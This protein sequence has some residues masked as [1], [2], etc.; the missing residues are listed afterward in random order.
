M[1]IYREHSVTQDL[2][3]LIYKEAQKI[4]DPRPSNGPAAD[5]TLTDIIMYALAVFHLKHPS[6]LSSDDSRLQPTIQSN[7]KSLYHVERIPCDSYLRDVIDLIPTQNFRAFFTACFAHCQRRSWLKRYQYFK[8]GYLAPIDATQTFTSKKIH[9]QNCCIKNAD[10]PKKPTIY[11]HQL[12]AICIVRPG[13]KTVLPL[14][15]EPITQQVDASKNDCEVRALER[16]L[17][18]L[19]REHYHLKLILNFDDLYSKGPTLKLVLSHGHHFIAVAKNSDHVALVEAVKALELLGKVRYFSFSDKQGHQH[20][21]RYVNGVPLNQSHPD[22]LVNY[23]DYTE[24]DKEGKQLYHNSWVTSLTLLNYMY[25]MKVLRGGR[26][27][28]KIENETFNTLKH[29]GY[30]LE[31]NYGHG[32]EHLSS[33]FTCLMFTAF[34]MDQYFGQFS[35]R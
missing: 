20:W 4:P 11:Y 19:A 33:N 31:H 1:P 6:L 27:K 10:N 9:C 15:P 23:L 34:L 7:V 32:D 30:N 16:I 3:E 28:W 26:A 13:M 2:L 24:T 22:L 14:M 5:I 25:C 8:E 18:D 29:L 17:N 12:S 21:F 35:I